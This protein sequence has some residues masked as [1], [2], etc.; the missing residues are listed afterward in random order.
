MKLKGE[1][2]VLAWVGLVYVANIVA[3]KVGAPPFIYCWGKLVVAPL[4]ETWGAFAQLA[5]VA[6]LGF[7][8]WRR[9][10]VGAMQAGAIV[11]GVYGLPVIADALFRLGG[12]C[13]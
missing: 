7:C 5:S 6:Y 8:I 1:Q 11:L 10:A 13:G 3:V 2:W 9:G 4:Y 12:S